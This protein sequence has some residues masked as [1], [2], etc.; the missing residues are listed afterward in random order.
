MNDK[1]NMK[2]FSLNSNHAIAEKIAKAAG[3]PLGKL[4]SRQF[5]DGEIQ[6]NIEESVRGFDVFIIQ[7]TSFPVNNHLMELLIMVDACNRASANS[8]NVVIPYFGYA[9]QDRTAAPREPITAKLVA[10]MLVKAGVNRVL[11]LDLHAV[12]VQGFFDIPVD[13]LYTVPLFAKHYCDKGLT[14]DDV[15]VVS[16]KNSGVKRARSL[17]EHLDAPIAIIDYAQDDA[18]RNEGYIIGEVAGKKAIL[19]DDILNTGRTFTEAAKIVDREGATEIYAVSSHGLFVDG[20]AEKLDTVPI[21]EILVTDSVDTKEKTP[22]NIQYITASELIA[23]AIVRIQERKPVS[24][25]FAY[26]KK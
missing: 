3:I 18:H 9:R 1:K 7:S 6:V 15:V 5:S 17:A 19:I 14:G 23:D 24:P 4:S 10:N 22:K 11:T 26:N 13:N 25:L 21:K 8:V 12:Q 16:P 2:L 20:A